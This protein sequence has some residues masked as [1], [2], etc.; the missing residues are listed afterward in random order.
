MP[1]SNR[2]TDDQ[3]MELVNTCRAS[4]LSDK[5]WC[6]Q[7]NISINSFYN[8]VHRLRIHAYQIPNQACNKQIINLTT[9]PDVVKVDIVDEG[10]PQEIT[11]PEPTPHIDNSYT[12][13][14]LIGEAVIRFSNNAD[15]KL[16]GKIIRM[17]GGSYAG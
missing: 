5:D 3:W 15:P 10:S 16:A 12:V 14:I 11:V 9:V 2:R 13:E 6:D 8:A 1:R 17:I 4:G 7:N